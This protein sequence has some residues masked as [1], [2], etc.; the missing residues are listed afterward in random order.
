MFGS[1]LGG[2]QG[3]ANI[4]S[5]IIGS[6]RRRREQKNAQKEFG[7]YKQQLENI[8]TSNLY[9]NMEN[10]YEDLTINQREA[11]FVANQQNQ[12]MAN[13]MNALS[14][15]AGGSGIAALAQAMGNQATTNAQRAGAS[16][17]QQ[18]RQNQILSAQR[19][20]QINQAEIG[21]EYTSRDKQAQKS[22]M[23]LGM[24]GSRLSAANLARQ[25]ATQS[26]LGGVGQMMGSFAGMQGAGD[27]MQGQGFGESTGSGLG[28]FID[29]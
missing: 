8:D 28:G 23:M 19:Q 25:Q 12:G 7:M 4:A 16:I 9:K 1:I 11:E 17:G 26:I 14:G 24:A 20:A 5:G 2:V 10:E 29:I 3:G 22:Q 13:T 15:S 6:G 18:E 21:G 27:I